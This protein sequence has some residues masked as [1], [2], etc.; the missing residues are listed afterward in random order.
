[1]KKLLPVIAGL[2]TVAG[3]HAQ[4]QTFNYTGTIQ[5]F[6]VPACVTTLT[7]EARGAQGGYNTSSGT[8]PGM[9]AIMIGTFTVTPGQTLKILVGEQPS[10][11]TGTGNGGGG[12]TFVTD[13]AN[14][15]LIVAGGGG[16]SS[17]TTDSPDK[18]G[19]I[20]TTGGTGAAGGGT[21]GTNGSGGNIGSSGFQ[22][23]AGG[24]L[25]TNGFDGWTTQTGGMA[26]VNGGSGGTANAPARGGFGGG[27]SGSSYVVGGGGGGYSGGGSGGNSTAGVGGGG[28]SYNGGTNQNNTGGA[29][30]G[31]GMVIIT[32]SAA[33]GPAFIT[34]PATVCE[35]NTMSLTAATVAGATSY[36]WT[37][38]GTATI[39]SGQGTNAITMTDVAGVNTVSVTATSPCGTSAP[40][41]LTYT[42][43]PTPVAGISVPSATVCEGSAVTMTGSGTGTYAW[44]SGG[45]GTTETVTVSAQTTYTLTVTNA[46]CS[47]TATQTIMTNPNPVVNLGPDM[48]ECDMATLDAQHAGS[49][50][51]WSN[52][53][54]TQTLMVMSSGTYSVVVTDA[55]GCTGADE[56]MVTITAS[57]VVNLGSDFSACDVAVLDAQN[58][59][60]AYLW[61]DN[62]TAQT[63]TVT[64]SGTYSVVVTAANG[65]STS[66]QVTATINASPVVTGSAAMNF[67][68]VGEPTVQLFESPAGG[69]WSGNGV[70]GNTFEP[71]TAG[72]G[73]HDLVYTYTDSVGCTGIDTISITVDL[74]LGQGAAN[75]FDF[76]VYPNP[77][78][79]MLNIAFSNSAE[80]V[81]VEMLDVNG[82]SVFAQQYDV[83][84]GDQK[85]FDLSGE[86]NGIYLLKVTQGNEVSTQRIIVTK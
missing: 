16:G 15:P 8:Q 19:N 34:G 23:G 70:F 17:Q 14:A 39:L 71:D 69:S 53:A 7:I 72:A 44:S 62:S 4:S 43:N 74:C 61:S 54:T 51:L 83:N 66:D 18:H 1:M 5:T 20:T 50:Y 28:G 46:G 73:T 35:G 29:N 47:G 38:S 77:T 22:S 75:A 3:L 48:N 40:T 30:T 59:G 68:C 11:T 78:N 79:G 26:F 32:Y 36:T 52:S 64:A 65:C 31:H 6:T 63:L 45:T 13:N 2:C 12:G 60:S 82:R 33:A 57:P 81:I 86:A 56:V 21:G 84:A 37:V 42:V 25:L 10:L 80:N 9:G 27:G 85:Q 67:V 58:A 55:N 76:Q 24:G 49:T 41:T